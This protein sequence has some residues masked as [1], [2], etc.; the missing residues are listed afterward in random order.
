M[1]LA[2]GLLLHM[3]TSVW[4]SVS[5]FPLL[6]SVAR[7]MAFELSPRFALEYRCLILCEVFSFTFFGVGWGRQTEWRGLKRKV[8]EGQGS[9]RA[10]SHIAG[11]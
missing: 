4:E 9:G 5:G 1:C 7:H 6:S 10:S 11:K 3:G 8:N 2:L